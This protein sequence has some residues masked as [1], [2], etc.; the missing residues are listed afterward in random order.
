MPPRWTS[1]APEALADRDID[2]AE[3]EQSVAATERS[4]ADPPLLPVLMRRYV[5]GRLGRRMLLGVVV[6]DMPGERVVVAVSK[7]SRIAK[8]LGR[9]EP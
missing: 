9:A 6:E 1:H 8:D 4:V 7:T 5:D 3:V 2:R